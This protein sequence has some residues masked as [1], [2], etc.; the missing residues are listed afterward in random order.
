MGERNK[1]AINIEHICF[2]VNERD[3]F[4]ALMRILDALPEIYGVVFC[5]TRAETQ[6]VAEKLMANKYSAE[7]LHGDLSQAQ[8]DTVMRKFRENSSD[9]S[10]NRC[11]CS[12]NRCKRY[13]PY[14]AL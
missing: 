12:R 9:F 3:R 5:R 10:C 7:A 13:N 6:T 2:M 14:S 11:C 8:R 1:A 4:I